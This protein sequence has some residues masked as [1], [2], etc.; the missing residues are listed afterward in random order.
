M[1]L[2]Y[3]IKCEGK[4][5]RWGFIYVCV[6]SDVSFRS[7]CWTR[8]LPYNFIYYLNLPYLYN[9]YLRRYENNVHQII[10]CI[11]FSTSANPYE[12]VACRI[13]S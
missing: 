1:K 2:F 3:V 8:Y 5:L 13:T 12:T 11:T 10:Y 9:S 6:G 4:F 7:Y